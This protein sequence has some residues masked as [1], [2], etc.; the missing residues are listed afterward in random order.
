MD[1]LVRGLPKGAKVLDL[2][3][4]G[5]SFSY[6]STEA[7]VLAVD[8]AFP[9]GAQPCFARLTADSRALPFRDGSL[10]VVVCNHTL[11]HFEEIDAAVAEIDRLLKEGGHLWVAVPD[12]F[13]FDDWLY[14]R[15]FEGGGHVNRFSLESLIGRVESGTGLRAVRYKKLH[16]GFVYLNPPDP[17]KLPY[18]PP[19]ARR[20]A[21]IPPRFLEAGVRW[22][23]WLTRKTDR[24]LGTRTSQYGWGVVFR[25]VP[26]GAASPQPKEMPADFNVCHACGAGHVESSL[27]PLLRRRAL[28]WKFYDCP[29]CGKPNLFVR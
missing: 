11:E 10:D 25:R 5:G 17:A 9:S 14:R 7:D 21:R 3:A 26:A 24:L 8:L 28:L 22:L 18:Y 20:L 1:D 27:T 19:P 23:N 4:G 15:L 13:L 2:G 6:R 12:G 29:S 16:S